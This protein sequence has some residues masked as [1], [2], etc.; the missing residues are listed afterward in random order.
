MK[1]GTVS[2]IAATVIASISFIGCQQPSTTTNKKTIEFEEIPVART[3]EAKRQIISTKKVKIDD[4]EYNID[5][6]TLLKT[7]DKVGKETFG[8]VKGVDGKPIKDEDGSDFICRTSNKGSG[9]DHTTLLQAHGKLWSIT[10]FECGPGAMYLSELEQA[11]DGKLKVKSLHYIDQSNEWG[12]FVH[13][14]GMATPWGTHL[15]SEEYEPNAAMITKDGFIDTNGDGKIDEKDDTDY[16]TMYMYYSG[17]AK[18]KS[19]QKSVNPYYYGWTPE[20]KILDAN[21]KVEYKKHY[22]MGRIARE[23]SYVMPDKKTVYQGDDGTNGVLTMFIAD[24][25][26]DL[27]SGTLYA[28]RWHQLPN[29]DA[30]LSWISLGHATDKEI[31]DFVSRRPTFDKMFDKVEPNKDGTCP[32]TYKSINT[33]WGHECLRLKPGMWK[34]ASRLET[35]RYAAMEGATTEFRKM[36]GITYDPD[37][38]RLYIAM[39]EIAKGMEKAHEEQDK[40]GPDHIQMSKNICGA[41]FYSNLQGDIKDVTGTKINS[42]YVLTDMRILIAGKEKKYDEKKDPEL[43]SNKCD[44]DNI[45]SPDNLTYLPKSN[46]LIIGEDTKLHQNDIIWAYDVEKKKLTR[47]FSTP[48]GSETT[49]PFWYPNING[50]GYLMGVVQHPYGESDQDKRKD[51]SNTK[52]IESTVGYFGP[53]PALD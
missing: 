4:K 18:E 17:D 47:I 19:T 45:A 31:R 53:F 15:G 32:L 42:K 39:T 5:Y 11:N 28:A 8:L 6:H 29:G 35:R 49:S 27:S 13:C 14:A 26:G 30:A 52:E 3:D 24:K 21:G 10:Q 50:F 1:I 22:A 38:K 43:V 40:G 46:I 48:Y 2:I 37:H 9:P 51:K 44:V 20:V 33:T 25:E 12:G 36:E 23:L 7:G 16:N 41:V 34:Y